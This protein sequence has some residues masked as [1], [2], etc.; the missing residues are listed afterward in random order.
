MRWKRDGGWERT[1]ELS[2]RV[3][4]VEPFRLNISEETCRQIFPMY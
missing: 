1:E 2:D 4:H 3:R